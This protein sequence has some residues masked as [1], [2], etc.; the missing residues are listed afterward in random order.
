MVKRFWWS[1]AVWFVFATPY[2]LDATALEVLFATWGTAAV[3]AWAVLEALIH[4]GAVW[5][6]VGLYGAAAFWASG[7]LSRISL[8]RWRPRRG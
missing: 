2:L 3:W 1:A 6:A 5:F 7:L 4:I 8:P